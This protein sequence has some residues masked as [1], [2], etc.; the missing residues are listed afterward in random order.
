MLFLGVP[1]LPLPI[2]EGHTLKIPLQYT[3]TA[4]LCSALCPSAESQASFQEVLP[5]PPSHFLCQSSQKEQRKGTHIHNSSPQLPACDTN[6][7]LPLAVT[8]TSLQPP[9]A[10]VQRR[11]PLG[12]QE[13]LGRSPATSHKTS[14][15]TYSSDGSG[16]RVSL[17]KTEL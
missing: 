7:K 12:Y 1:K 11:Q 3:N 9:L 14:S 13:A 5:K 8:T 17:Q 16:M 2:R 4:P 10:R 15:D 6:I